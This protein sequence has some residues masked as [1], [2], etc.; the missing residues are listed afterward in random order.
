MGRIGLPELLVVLAIVLVIFGAKRIPDV[1]RAV[2]KGIKEL[3][4]AVEGKK[5]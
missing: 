3:K 5:S 2:G 1:M 4:N